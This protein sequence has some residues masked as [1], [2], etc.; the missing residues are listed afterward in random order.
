MGSKTPLYESHVEAGARIVDFGGWDMPL[1]YGS[2]KEEHHAVR[3]NAGVFDVSHM[4]VVDLSGP[5]VG[6]FLRYLVAN[7]IARLDSH[8]RALYT[9]ML[10]EDGGVIDDL[11][12]YFVGDNDYR[13]VVNA[14]TREKDLA[15]IRKQAEAFDVDVVER[16]ELAMIA[17]QGPRARELAAP[18]IAAEYRDSALGL[19][20][21]HA[22]QAAGWFVARTGYTGE[23]GWEIMLPAA[24]APTVWDRLLAAGVEPCGLGA[25][26]TLRLEAAMNLYGTDMDESIS[27]L[28]AGLAW[29]VAWEP[30][31]RDFIGRAAL[32]K[33]RENTGRQRFVGLLLEDKGV[34]RNHQRVVVE[35]VGEGEITSGGFSPTIGRSIALARLPAGDYDR[36]QVDIR[37]KLLDVRIVKTPF[38]RSGQVRIDI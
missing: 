25:R 11:I 19:K 17:V 4:T 16:A 20:P 21:F 28:E 38:V 2:Q 12:I 24:D 30:A 15:W 6:D 31:E 5:R 36:A 7:D 8:G 33:Q 18:C 35:G 26:D 22:M 14:A 23:D 10:N 13:L 1:H 29:T 37:G 9:C 3:G 34:L 27:P 32:E